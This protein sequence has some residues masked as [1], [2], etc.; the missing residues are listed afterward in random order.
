MEQIIVPAS[1]KIS[2]RSAAVAQAV[3]MPCILTVE[4]DPRRSLTIKFAASD[5]TLE[6]WPILGDAA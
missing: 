3:E 1:S 6:L 5:H 4:A 2:W